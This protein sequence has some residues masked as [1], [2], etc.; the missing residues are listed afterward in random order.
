[1]PRV[2]RFGFPRLRRGLGETEDKK[3]DRAAREGEVKRVKGQ[4]GYRVLGATLT[5]RKPSSLPS[6]RG[7]SG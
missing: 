4:K 3:F 2:L 7:V 1:M 6:L 5:R